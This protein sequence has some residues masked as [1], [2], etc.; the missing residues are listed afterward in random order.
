MDRNALIR[1]G[2]YWVIPGL[3]ALARYLSYACCIVPFG[4]TIF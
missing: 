3:L 1:I 2:V 4:L